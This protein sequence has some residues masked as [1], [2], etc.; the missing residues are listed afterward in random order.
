VAELAEL[1]ESQE[2]DVVETLDHLCER[3]TLD[4]QLRWM[5]GYYH[6]R[7]PAVFGRFEKTRALQRVLRR[8][9]PEAWR[10]AEPETRDF[11]HRGLMG[12][13]WNDVIT[14]ATDD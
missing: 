5:L 11:E 7:F 9:F 13:F 1:A 2:L 8:T 4:P 10:A 3:G 12:R 6:G 14:S